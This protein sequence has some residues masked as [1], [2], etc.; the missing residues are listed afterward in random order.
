VIRIGAEPSGI[1]LQP[2]LACLTAHEHAEDFTWQENFQIR[3]DLVASGDGWVL[4]PHKLIGGLELP[5]S[6]L[7]TVRRNAKRIRRFHKVAKQELAR[8]A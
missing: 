5:R 4:V 6:T 3:G 1:P 8:R 7:E 2:G